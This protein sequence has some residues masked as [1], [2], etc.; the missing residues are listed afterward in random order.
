MVIAFPVTSSTDTL[1]EA[2]ISLVESQG[3]V[4][5]HHLRIVHTADGRDLAAKYATR[6]APFC[7][8]VE[9]IGHSANAHILDNGLFYSAV[10]MQRV[11]RDADHFLWL[12]PGIVPTTPYSFDL[13][14]AAMASY[15][16]H[17]CFTG[18]D[19][20]EGHPH[21]GKLVALPTAYL[22]RNPVLTKMLLDRERSWRNLLTFLGTGVM[23]L[24]TMTV[25]HGSCLFTESL[26][27]PVTK[28]K[29]PS[30]R[31]SKPKEAPPAVAAPES[32]SD[33]LPESDTSEVKDSVEQPAEP[34]PIE[35]PADKTSDTP[36][37][38]TVAFPR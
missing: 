9:L 5:D 24:P 23:F 13:L 35:V 30:P 18:S 22:S 16:K 29:S 36:A 17:T 28:D 32:L 14:F 34:E 19:A 33:P 7:K 8:S 38:S 2:F 12:E 26:V 21:P 15:P 10:H 20:V 37:P 31:S 25:G 6:V 1:A 27:T 3:G 4:T 11:R